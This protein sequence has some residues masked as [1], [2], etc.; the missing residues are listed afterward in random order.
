MQAGYNS[1][2]LV[3]NYF[4]P[5]SAHIA[6]R[7]VFTRTLGE[8]CCLNPFNLKQM[9]PCDYLNHKYVT[10]C[11]IYLKGKRK[12][13]NGILKL[14]ERKELWGERKEEGIG[15]ASL[16]IFKPHHSWTWIWTIREHGALKDASRNLSA[17]MPHGKIKDKASDA[18]KTAKF[19][20]SQYASYSVGEM[21]QFTHSVQE[22]SR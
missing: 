12:F 15:D 13:G 21:P 4:A 11:V 10:Q 3:P 17:R 20:H 2:K 9:G 6:R 5:G 19:P 16:I 22:L 1:D 8:F 7:E 14:F 18:Q